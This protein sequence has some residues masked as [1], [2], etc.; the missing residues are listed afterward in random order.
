MKSSSTRLSRRVA[1]CA[2]FAGVASAA[3][4]A[5][6]RVD[7]LRFSNLVF[8]S[9]DVDVPPIRPAVIGEVSLSDRDGTSAPAIVWE[10]RP[11]AIAIVLVVEASR[12]WM[13]GDDADADVPVH[14]PMGGFDFVQGILRGAV[15]SDAPDGS[16]LEIVTYDDVAKV[17]L[18]WTSLRRVPETPLG[19]RA[20]FDAIGRTPSSGL[21][22]ALETLRTAEAARK[23]VIVVGS[24][25]VSDEA[26]E[27]TLLAD[28]ELSL[29]DLDVETAAILFEDA[30]TD[31]RAS[32]P[33]E[34]V[35]SQHHEA[36]TVGEGI[37]ALSSILETS[38]AE[39]HGRFELTRF[40]WDGEAHPLTLVAGAQSFRPVEIVLPER[41]ASKQ[42]SPW[43]WP[44]VGLALIVLIALTALSRRTR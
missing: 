15:W 19:A 32:R 7:R 3:V 20:D 39:Y 24:G 41:S 22:L 38:K 28:V 23:I 17:V 4:V 44:L 30:E 13:R 5:A 43:R 26:R 37:R 35:V 34:K 2:V 11:S 14:Q 18:P 29:R 25:A 31:V 6:E 33:L 1:A 36:R 8:P 12:A 9:I 27:V 21:R 42:L 16:M 40:A 10:R